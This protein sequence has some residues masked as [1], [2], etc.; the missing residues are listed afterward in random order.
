MVVE[1]NIST[2]IH[3]S[4]I[5]GFDIPVPVNLQIVV[6]C[7]YHSC[8]YGNHVKESLVTAIHNHIVGKAVIV[9]HSF[10]HESVEF[11][12][13]VIDALGKFLSVTLCPARTYT[14]V[15]IHL[16]PV[17]LPFNVISYAEQVLHIVVE[18]REEEVCKDLRQLHS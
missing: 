8:H 12:V 11:P 14:I 13:Q 3:A 2:Y 5:Y 4:S 18:F 16:S 6:A 9:F 15:N 10:V 7:K 17:V 1:C